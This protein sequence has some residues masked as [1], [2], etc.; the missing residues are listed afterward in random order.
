MSPRSF[1]RSALW[2]WTE[3][4]WIECVWEAGFEGHNID[5]K[6]IDVDFVVRRIDVVAIRQI[7]AKSNF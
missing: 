2:W 1:V 5:G 6:D 4:A 7:S 3:R